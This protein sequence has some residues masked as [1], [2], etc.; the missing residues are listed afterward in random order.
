VQFS[1]VKRTPVY[2][3]DIYLIIAVSFVSVVRLWNKWDRKRLT[4]LIAF[5]R[6]ASLGS[7]SAARALSISPS[8]VS[9]SVQRLEQQLG[10]RCLRARRARGH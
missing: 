6:S 3:K 4:G 10:F 8:A 5:V 1:K 2:I 7:Y 9:K